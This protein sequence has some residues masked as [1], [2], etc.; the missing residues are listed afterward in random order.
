MWANGDGCLNIGQPVR[1]GPYRLLGVVTD[2]KGLKVRVE[3][4]D[5]NI[6]PEWLDAENV[7]A[8]TPEEVGQEGL[9]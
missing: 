2:A 7:E 1:V 6:A 4:D 3:F 9:F 5:P 8:Y